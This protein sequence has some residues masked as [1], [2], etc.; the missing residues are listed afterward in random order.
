M[1]LSFTGCNKEAEVRE[2]KRK[3]TLHPNR[4]PL[5]GNPLSLLN[6]LA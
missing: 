5:Q 4:S 6:V 2:D 1:L 3:E